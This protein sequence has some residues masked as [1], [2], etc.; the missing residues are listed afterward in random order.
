MI[1]VVAEEGDEEPMV[2]VLTGRRRRRARAAEAAEAQLR[3]QKATGARK[4]LR[5]VVFIARRR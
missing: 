2:P 3:A 4:T 1:V 5:W